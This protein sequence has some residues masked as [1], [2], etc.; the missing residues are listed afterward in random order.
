MAMWEQDPLEIFVYYSDE[1]L[2]SVKYDIYC[3]ADIFQH[4]KK[5]IHFWTCYLWD[6]V[7]GIKQ[8]L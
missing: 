6:L 3:S 4:R 2:V 1:T 8:F 7:F 5:D